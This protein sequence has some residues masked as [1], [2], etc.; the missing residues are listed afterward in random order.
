MCEHLLNTKVGVLQGRKS[1]RVVSGSKRKARLYEG[2]SA[3]FGNNANLDEL[4]L[5]NTHAGA[6][7]LG[8]DK[9]STAAVC[10]VYA[11]ES[12]RITQLLL[13]AAPIARAGKTLSETRTISWSTSQPFLGEW[14]TLLDPCRECVPGA[15]HAQS[16]LIRQARQDKP[17]QV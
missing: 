4:A 12:P 6:T 5:I 1:S 15:G 17:P 16:P 14:V 9:E 2:I 10:H 3:L 7:V 8:Q 11:H 13:N